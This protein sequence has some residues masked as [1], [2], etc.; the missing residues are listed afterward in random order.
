MSAIT[1]V[2]INFSFIFCMIQVFLSLIILIILIIVSIT[3]I[4]KVCFCK[5]NNVIDI[6]LAKTTFFKEK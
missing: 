5:Y 3:S 6:N 4:S 2:R 1:N